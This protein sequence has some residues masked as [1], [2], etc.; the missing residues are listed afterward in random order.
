MICR[1][2]A[3]GVPSPRGNRGSDREQRGEGISFGWVWS[4]N[5]GAISGLGL[6]WNR[7]APN[8]PVMTIAQLSGSDW[9]DLR[10]VPN[11]FT[12]TTNDRAGVGGRQDIMTR[13][14]DI[15]S[16]W[17]LGVKGQF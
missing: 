16:I 1:R 4:V 3:R 14:L 7:G 15:G 8:D 6:R 10:S 5:P 17:T 12:V 11:G 2:G 13:Y 9:R